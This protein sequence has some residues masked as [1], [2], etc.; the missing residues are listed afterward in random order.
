M[1]SLINNALQP[2]VDVVT[3]NQVRLSSVKNEISSN[4]INPRNDTSIT[5]PEDVVT[6]SSA[7][8]G[9]GATSSQKKPSVAVSHDE[10]QALLASDFSPKGF[11]VYG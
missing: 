10:K 8:R 7:N 6:L 3:L 5:L 9:E 11:S 2:S 4:K 1:S